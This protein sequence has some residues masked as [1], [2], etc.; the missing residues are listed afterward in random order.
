M[1]R[2][3]IT[4]I[5]GQDGWYLGTSLVQAGYQVVGVA[6]RPGDVP[7]GVG[8]V[9]GDVRD[10][11]VLDEVVQQVRPDEIYHLAADSSVVRSWDA[12]D[13]AVRALVEGTER[14]IACATRHAPDAHLVLAGSCEV[15]GHSPV[16][17]QTE[18]T[19][20]AP[21][22]PYGKGKALALTFAREAR[23][24]GARVSVAILYNHESPRRPAA[25]LSRKV[26]LGA[27]RIAAGQESTLTLGSLEAR[28]D[29]SHAADVA[30][31]LWRMGCAP[32]PGDF[33]VGSGVLRSVAEL[34]DAA[35]TSLGLDFARYVV[36]D[37]ALVRA[38]DPSSLTADTARARARLGWSPR[39]PFATMI[40]EMVAADVGR[41]SRGEA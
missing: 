16:V 7:A 2:A 32:E 35:F 17:P 37:P 34:C 25:F 23:A 12:P 21:V 1:K 30:D 33:V 41:L 31:A 9:Q 28:R 38:V 29:W 11:V 26:T 6:R 8:L 18:D 19:P 10:P 4:G 36:S 5:T 22:S 39:I 14:M 20:L 24:R 40:A 15:F 13:D 27:A 3:L